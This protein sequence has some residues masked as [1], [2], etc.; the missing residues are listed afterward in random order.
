[1]YYGIGVANL[2]IQV[3]PDIP[4]GL[5]RTGH[6]IIIQFIQLHYPEDFIVIL[7]LRPKVF[8]FVNLDRRSGEC[9]EGFAVVSN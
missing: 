6:H 4:L 1:V 7:L 2:Y 3:V 9:I 8:Q 5:N